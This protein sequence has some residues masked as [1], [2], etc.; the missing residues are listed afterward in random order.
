[1]KAGRA[2]ECSSLPRQPLA[3]VAERGFCLLQEHGR[4]AQKTSG[5]ATA[6]GDQLRG[7]IDELVQELEEK[8]AELEEKDQIV[9]ELKEQMAQIT[10]LLGGFAPEAAQRLVLE[11]PEPESLVCIR[12]KSEPIS[13]DTDT[14]T[15]VQPCHG[16]GALQREAR[17]AA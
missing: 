2:E 4:T 14:P 5:Y 10:H 8:N 17:L 15:T 7:R 12:L 1:M 11:Q 13:T 16:Q 9:A 6:E 3:A